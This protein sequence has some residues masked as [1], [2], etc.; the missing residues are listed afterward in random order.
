MDETTPAIRVS[1]QD[2]SDTMRQ[3]CEGFGQGRLDQAEFETRTDRAL[4]AVTHADLRLLTAD[5]PVDQRS[6]TR[7][8]RAELVLETRWWVAG[9]VVTN[10]IWLVQSLVAEHAVRYWP[11]LPLAIWALILLGAVI[12]PRSP[13]KAAGS[14]ALPGSAA[15]RVLDP[16]RSVDGGG[17]PDPRAR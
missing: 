15:R 14:G 9:A 10:G 5:L 1:D 4:A 17:A 13:G 12:A 8:E 16:P 7:A 6:V 11:A 3:L 2:R